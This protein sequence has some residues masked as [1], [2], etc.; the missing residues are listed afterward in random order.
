[1]KSSE[2]MVGKVFG[3]LTV[4]RL[5][6]NVNYLKKFTCR[7]A[8]GNTTEVYQAHLRS[9]HTTTCGCS[10][11]T[12]PRRKTHG[13]AGSKLYKVY[14]TLVARCHTPTSSCFHKYGAKGITVCPEWRESYEAF[15]EWAL[16]NGYKPGLT[17]DRKNN[18]LGYSPDN[19][20]FTTPTNQ[21]INRGRAINNTSGYKG[22]SFNKSKG[23][24]VSRI[25]VKNKRLEIGSYPT[26]EEAYAARIK[27]IA[28]NN[29]A[30]YHRA[31]AYD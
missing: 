12:D 8:C 21:A 19:C 22:V 3:K 30:E 4:I 10:R 15:K 13:D 26:A 7:C 9:G 1:M 2:S 29:L 18:L 14:Y 24:W 25:N 17:V 23:R 16:N 28:D 31:L 11:V 20:R 27:Y 6:S 5:V